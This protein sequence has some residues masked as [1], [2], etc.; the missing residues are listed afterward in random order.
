MVINN[1]NRLGGNWS[2]VKENHLRLL[3]KKQNWVTKSLF[4][5]YRF[6]LAHRDAKLGKVELL[7]FTIVG[8]GKRS[9]SEPDHFLTKQ[10]GSLKAE[11]GSK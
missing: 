10:E 11:Y 3:N 4:T 1:N 5:V 9:A 7:V 6:R 2:S 8:G